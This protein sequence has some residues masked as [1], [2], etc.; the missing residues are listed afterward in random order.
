MAPRFE[1]SLR[2]STRDHYAHRTSKDLHIEPQAPVLNVRSIQRNVAVKRRILASFHLPQ[3]R[4]TWKHIQP[5]QVRYVVLLHFGRDRWPRPDKA[6]IAA[7]HVVELR[8]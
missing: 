6:H 2:T 3:A 4:H 1:T 5:A 8:Q 7:Q